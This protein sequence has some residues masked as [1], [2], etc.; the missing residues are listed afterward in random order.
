MSNGAVDV[1]N[2]KS[3]MWSTAA[4]NVP[5]RDLAA[6]SLPNQGWVMFSG[7]ASTGEQYGFIFHAVTSYVCVL[8]L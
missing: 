4:L 7:G 3:G 1:V 2:V 5:R 8:C 6:T